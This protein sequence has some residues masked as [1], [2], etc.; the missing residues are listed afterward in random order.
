MWEVEDWREA[1]RSL[2]EL[3]VAL[4]E[5]Q[6]LQRVRKVVLPQNLQK[7]YSRA[8]TLILA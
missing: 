2:Q 8:D 4:A 3:R 7:G 1:S 5:R 6:Q